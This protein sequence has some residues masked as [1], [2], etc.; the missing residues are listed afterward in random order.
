MK[1]LFVSFLCFV[2]VCSIV[3]FV[4]CDSNKSGSNEKDSTTAAT[5][6]EML[7]GNHYEGE[8][9][10]VYPNFPF[11]YR[12]QK[13]G[14]ST[15]LHME[16]I[17]VTINKINKIDT[18]MSEYYCPFEI[19]IIAEGYCSESF[20]GEKLYLYLD[21]I[22]HSILMDPPYAVVGE[23]GKVM[24]S[25]RAMVHRIELISFQYIDILI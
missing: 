6:E 20:A 25:G 3:P 16:K 12:L 17:S 18:L 11:D 23:D 19:L 10:S 14:K 8:E 9:L 24:W 22:D 7:F 13:N 1:K 21:T 5:P 4:G 15:I 2:I